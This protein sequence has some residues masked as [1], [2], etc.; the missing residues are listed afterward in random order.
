MNAEEEAQLNDSEGT[1]L[2][3]FRER[4]AGRP[5]D[6]RRVGSVPEI[7]GAAAPDELAAAIFIDSPALVCPVSGA[8]Q[9]AEAQ[10]TARTRGNP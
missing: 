2:R 10:N 4:F 8:V 7:R 6:V 5:G 1:I 9:T 3:G